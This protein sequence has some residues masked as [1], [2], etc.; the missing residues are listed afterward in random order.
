[1][2]ND[3]AV[4]P[5]RLCA[6]V[7]GVLLVLVLAVG[8]LRSGREDAPRPVATQPPGQSLSAFA[9]D[10]TGLRR[11]EL[12][13]LQAVLDDAASSDSLRQSAQERMMDIRKWMELEATIEEVLN[14][15]GYEPSVVT[16]HA[17]SVNVVVRSAQLN[18]QE[19]QVILELVVRETGVSG[20][21][22]KIIPIN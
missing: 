6:A 10:R 11:E 21:N 5:A 19:A 2:T 12:E 22:V 17:D 14:A 8:G 15:R 7:S 4:Y 3:P 20:G 13:Q 16:V 1:M 18:A 9:A